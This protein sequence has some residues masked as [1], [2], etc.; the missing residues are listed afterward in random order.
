M[1]AEIIAVGSELLL[2]QITNTNAKFM[3]SQLAVIGIDVYYQTVVGDNPARLEEVIQI[4]E[5]RADLL[6]FSG[7]L[8]PTKDDLTKE[9]IARHIGVELES[10]NQALLSIQAYFERTGRPMTEN[11]KKQA[12][13]LKGSTVLENRFGMAPG[14][15]L[16]VNNRT[17]MLL[18][19]PPHEME[20]MFRDE[21]LPCLQSLSGSQEV[22]V[23]TVV[24]FFG[25]G[26][27]ELEYK[28]RDLLEAQ[29]NP[30]I[31]PLA[32]KDAVTLRITAKAQSAEAAH[33]LIEP[34]LSELHKQV[35]EY[36][37]GTDEDTLSSKAASLLISAGLSISAAESLTAGLFTGLLAE[38]PGISASLRGGMTVYDV[39][40][41]TEQLG[42]DP[43]LIETYGTVSAQCA[44]GLAEKI[45]EYFQTDIG[46]GLTGAAGPDTHDGKPAGT[47][48]IGLAFKDRTKTYQ[49]RL[50]GSRNTN[51][52]RAANFA[53]YYLIRELEW[54]KSQN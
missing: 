11:N 7:G 32:S 38:E 41:K 14:M 20:P 40:A 31:A 26:E 24:K 42:L 49:L 21:A 1:R 50:S 33:S 25:I 23:S 45:R 13:V 17:Y 22:I 9:T 28:V 27:A 29:T 44:E 43:K 48:W 46:I 2:G 47:V 52:L 16:A 3:S 6:I 34:V 19:G 4:A 8:G 37:Y 51:R 10:N 35:G 12:L 15:A 18:P 53:L 36:I 5:G 39:Q 54:A 30:T